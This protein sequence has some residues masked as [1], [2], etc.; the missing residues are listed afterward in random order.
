MPQEDR[1][2]VEPSPWKLIKLFLI[3]AA[4]VLLG[5][6]FVIYPEAFDIAPPGIVKFIGWLCIAF[7]GLGIPIVGAQVIQRKPEFIID[8]AGITYPKWSED[9]IKWTDISDVSSSDVASTKFVVLQ[10]AGAGSGRGD[11][12]HGTGVKAAV[13]GVNRKMVGGELTIP[14]VSA[15][16]SLAEVMAAVARY[17]TAA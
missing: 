9:V 3:A 5:V 8:R 16:K 7:F 1:F 10:L 6:A 12:E 13:M 2:V 11:A 14:L 4:F 17:R 15:N